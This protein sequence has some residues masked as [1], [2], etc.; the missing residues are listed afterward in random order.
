MAMPP[1]ATAPARSSEPLATCPSLGTISA[2]CS[3]LAVHLGGHFWLQ[4]GH[5][6]HGDTSHPCSAP[7]L[8]FVPAWLRCPGHHAEPWG[9]PG[10]NPSSRGLLRR[11]GG[12]R[13]LY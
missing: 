9:A 1:P 2:V 7:L 8:P 4:G 10:P 12:L 11:L 5:A 13:N 6:G 3:G